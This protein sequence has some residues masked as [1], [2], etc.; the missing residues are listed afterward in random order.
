[1]G[2]NTKEEVIEKLRRSLVYCMKSGDVLVLYID[3]LAP[4]FKNNI[5]HK[6]DFPTDQI[7]KFLDFRKP[8]NYKK[9]LRN[10][11]D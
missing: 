1:M 8:E 9:L 6:D 10:E 2:K 3:K 11:E 7:F 5:S 4:D